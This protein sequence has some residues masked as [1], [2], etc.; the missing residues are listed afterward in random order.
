MS[1]M[2]KSGMSVMLAALC[3]CAS[4]SLT[5]QNFTTVFSLDG[6]DG[7]TPLGLVQATDGNL[8]GTTQASGGT[9]F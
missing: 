3:L 8:Y 5:A 4:G 9:I 6:S 1:K 2:K 7:G